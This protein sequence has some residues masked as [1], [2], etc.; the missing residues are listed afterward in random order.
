M[1][2]LQPVIW[3]EETGYVIYNELKLFGNRNF[4]KILVA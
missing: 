2:H 3:G 1:N 4:G